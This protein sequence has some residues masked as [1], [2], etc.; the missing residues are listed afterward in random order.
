MDD[1]EKEVSGHERQ[2]DLCAEWDALES[3]DDCHCNQEGSALIKNKK[4]KKELTS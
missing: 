3:S 4:G 1:E 2:L